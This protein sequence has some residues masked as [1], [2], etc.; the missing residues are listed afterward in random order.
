MSNV[1]G[2]SSNNTNTFQITKS[3]LYV[4]VVTLKTDDNAKLN[5]LLTEKDL[6]DQ[7]L[8]MNIKAKLKHTQMT[9]II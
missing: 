8:G 1:G 4:P 5:N 6:K 2:N 7:Y 3:Q 9:Q